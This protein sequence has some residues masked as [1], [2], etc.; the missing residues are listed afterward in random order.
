M[1]TGGQY[2]FAAI[3]SVLA[4]GCTGTGSRNDADSGTDAG[5]DADGDT[6][7]DG[8]ADCAEEWRDSTSKL[9]WEMTPPGD[10]VTWQ[11][12]LDRCDGLALCGHDDWR[13]PTIGELRTLMR[14]CAAIETGGTCGV[15]DDCLTPYCWSAACQGCPA[16]G[17]P[18]NGCYWPAGIG[19]ECSYYWSASCRSDD[20]SQAWVVTFGGGLD[21]SLG[22]YTKS[23][24]TY[25]R[26]VRGG[27]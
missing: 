13:M 24:T 12:G 16:G 22:F 25:V 20:A 26:C 5:G 4:F 6:D 8:D 21:S 17:E 10:Q 1:K 23:K 3:V 7:A 18:D 19:G 11:S 27:P 9:S 2:L 15:T 14:G